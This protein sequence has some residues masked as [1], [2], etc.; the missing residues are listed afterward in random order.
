M[1]FPRYI[2][3]IFSA[4]IVTTFTTSA[5][6]LPLETVVQTGYSGPVDYALFSPDGKAIITVAES[7]LK[8]W[9]VRTGKEIVTHSLPGGYISITSISMDG[10]YLCLTGENTQVLD[11]SSGK[12]QY[13]IS[14]PE[15]AN[16]WAVNYGAFLARQPYLV[17][18]SSA[19]AVVFRDPASGAIKHTMRQAYKPVLFSSDG[20]LLVTETGSAI[21]NTRRYF[22]YATETETMQTEVKTTE[23][24]TACFSPDNGVL[25]TAN[26][27][28][29]S[30]WNS[31][32]GQLLGTI[33]YPKGR[34]GEE[35][36]KAITFSPNGR[37]F[38]A[39]GG[40]SGEEG[41]NSGSVRVWDVRNWQ[42]VFAVDA[43]PPTFGDSKGA[44][45]TEIIY[46]HV[47]S[48]N[49]S[50]DGRYLIIAEN[51]K[52]VH[53]LDATTGRHLRRFSGN[54]TYVDGA[55]FSTDGRYLITEHW[56]DD[57]RLW[58]LQRGTLTQTFAGLRGEFN[59]IAFS[60]DG[61]HAAT[62]L[63][64]PLDPQAWEQA[65]NVH[66]WDLKAKRLT[67]SISV[68]G[69]IGGL[70]FSPDGRYLRGYRYEGEGLFQYYL[71]DAL[72]GKK[73]SNDQDWEFDK[74][75]SPDQQHVLTTKN[76]LINIATGKTVKTF[77]RIRWSAHPVAAFSPDGSILALGYDNGAVLLWNVVGNAQIGTL[78]YH[79]HPFNDHTEA[80]RGHMARISSV[81]F[82]PD[83]RFI[84]T[85]S[86]DL[87]ARLWD[88]QTG[89]E[90]RIFT[91]HANSVEY[92]TF[93]ADNR[94]L[95]TC[96]TDNTSKMW[97]TSTGT[98]LVT[99]I[100]V[101]KDDY[102]LITPDN[103]Y[104]ASKNAHRGVSFRKGM[105]AFPFEQFDLRLN[106][107]DLVLKN[108]PN[109]SPRLIEAYHKAYLKRL[110]KMNFSE[111]MLSDDVALPEV[112]IRRSIQGFSTTD[113]RLTLTATARD[114]NVPLDRINCWVNDTPVFGIDGINLRGENT[115]AVSRTFDLELS[116]GLNKIQVSALN[117]RG[118]ESIKETFE[119][120][121]TGPAESPDLYVIT[122][123]VS[124]YQ[125]ERLNLQYAAKDA[126][127][128]VALLGNQQQRYGKVHAFKILDGEATR[129]NILGMKEIL[130]QSRVND[131]VILFIAGH[132]LLDKDLN[133]YF[134]TS[135]ID[136]TQPA[137]RGLLYEELEGLLD[138]I[139]ARKKLLMMDTCHSGEVDKEETVLMAASDAESEKVKT[140][141]FRAA[142]P[143]NVS[144]KVGLNNSFQ[145]MQDMFAN[146]NRGSGAQVISAAG[147]AE[148]AYEGEGTA[149]GVFT[150][151]VLQGIQSKAADANGD[152]QIGVAELRDYVTKSVQ[153]LTQG[154]Q[155]PTS[156]RENLE[157]DFVIY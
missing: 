34:Y 152:G 115:L 33:S 87:T 142:V 106:R 18:A 111:E 109:S 101:G 65:A 91:G 71:W 24:T 116:Q 85:S 97:E 117:Q 133:Y 26:R 129:E 47:N 155:T 89:E 48:V 131:E 113:K 118:I 76:N 15:K 144:K 39:A 110:R 77:E 139:P 9:D 79:L 68:N 102:V 122:I 46:S 134:A 150:H 2:F 157:F 105:Q 90:I 43:Y 114:A 82:S 17:T 6:P 136:L 95:V 141:S 1:P 98:L 128:L 94:Y 81:N 54:S 51:D 23:I 27:A 156:R 31:T 69:S 112:E 28:T 84:A 40:W 36:P 44:G 3:W 62:A 153:K 10:R 119:L 103:Y 124:Q 60:P 99:L 21:D 30:F 74:I 73:L 92:V 147:G 22:I 50:P 38:A 61:Q 130:K 29:L 151:S 154:R 108:L 83:G 59:A 58:D 149:N 4:V 56:L 53:L 35:E 75:F 100:A 70:H 127:D 107:P 120:T 52:A 13:T 49:F 11:V 137:E 140:R 19:G 57:N 14:D 132:G 145:L 104:T 93:S 146:L 67:R 135:D 7:V 138:G 86:E 37:Y 121:Y 88:A 20:K 32:T 12:L 55:H 78:G 96:S 72:S 63:N 148:Y 80:C 5:Q 42:E 66:F 45:Q 123:G 25:V 8:L 125:N 41:A 64:E 126:R 143:I 16:Q